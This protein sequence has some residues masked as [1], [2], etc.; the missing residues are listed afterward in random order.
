MSCNC[1]MDSKI[2][3]IW[4]QGGVVTTHLV[5][6]M[7]SCTNT[8]RCWLSSTHR[9]L[10]WCNVLTLQGY[11]SN[12]VRWQ[13]SWIIHTAVKVQ[14]YCYTNGYNVYHRWL[15]A[16]A[17]WSPGRP[18]C[19]W[20]RC[21]L[22]KMSTLAIKWRFCMTS[23]AWVHFILYSRLWCIYL[24]CMCSAMVTLVVTNL[25]V[26][27]PLTIIHD[28]PLLHNVHGSKIMTL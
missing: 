6:G 24:V 21:S 17:I 16:R 14:P 9:I 4:D 3:F 15:Q 20:L 10:P 26:C 12:T 1:Y 22:I 25:L 2:V 7:Q 19:R 23:H 13:S 5:N 27:W 8:L 28:K 18:C 11:H